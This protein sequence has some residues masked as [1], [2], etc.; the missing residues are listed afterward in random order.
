MSLRG[1]GLGGGS[2][3]V[4]DVTPRAEISQQA[5]KVLPLSAPPQMRPD[6]TPEEDKPLVSNSITEDEVFQ[7][8]LRPMKPAPKGVFFKKRK[9]TDF[10]IDH[11]KSPEEE[12]GKSEL[13]ELFPGPKSVKFKSDKIKKVR[14]EKNYYVVETIEDIFG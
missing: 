4:T 7:R 14:E 3:A 13:D 10:E 12:S 6:L 2:G 1:R 8:P 11:S 5:A 9:R